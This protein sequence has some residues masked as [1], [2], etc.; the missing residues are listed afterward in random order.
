MLMQLNL[1]VKLLNHLLFNGRVD[2]TAAA[3]GSTD[4]AAFSLM[5]ALSVLKE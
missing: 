3:A 2:V 1:L 5:T 4:G